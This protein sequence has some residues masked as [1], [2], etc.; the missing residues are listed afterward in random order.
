VRCFNHSTSEAVGIC[1]ACGKGLCADCA[2]DLG[3]G[4]SCRG[5]HEQRVAANDALLT[6]SAQ[7]QDT[8][9]RAKYAA[10]VFFGFMGA[11]MSVYGLMYSKADM[12]LVLLGGGF[13]AFG[14]F[15]FVMQRKAF[16]AGSPMSNTS[17][18][19]TRDR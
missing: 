18:E 9:G 1:R 19:R 16:Q 7:L 11:V 8:A 6:K 3:F 4:L 15:L 17:L 14:G 12:F 5:E 10:P 13:L 2:V